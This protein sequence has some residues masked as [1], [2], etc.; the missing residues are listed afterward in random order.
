MHLKMPSGKW[1]PF[2]LG[3]NVLMIKM[4]LTNIAHMQYHLR[5][6]H[7]AIIPQVGKPKWNADWIIVL[8]MNWLA[9]IM[10]VVSMNILGYMTNM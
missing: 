5:K 8:I 3:L 10:P 7:D 4:I 2:C 9:L 1:P 6:Y